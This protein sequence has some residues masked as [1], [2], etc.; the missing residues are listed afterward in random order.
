MYQKPPGY[1][2]MLEK[3]KTAA[4]DAKLKED[5]AADFDAVQEARRLV[6]SCK[7]KPVSKAPSSPLNRRSA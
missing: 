2:A 3:E 6:G 5:Q 7:L 1:D 4:A